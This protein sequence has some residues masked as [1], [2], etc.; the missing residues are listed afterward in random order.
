MLSFHD[1]KIVN[2]IYINK[3]YNK[4]YHINNYMIFS[5]LAKM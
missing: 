5:L 1:A 3:Y 4:K 2:I